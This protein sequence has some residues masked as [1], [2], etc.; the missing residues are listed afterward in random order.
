MSTD[1]NNVTVQGLNR[2]QLRQLP[3]T[4]GR[5]PIE[6]TSELKTDNIVRVDFEQ[7][8]AVAS[9]TEQQKSSQEST[10]RVEQTDSVK[11]SIQKLSDSSQLITRKLEFHIDDASGKT[12]ITVK[13]SS[14]KEVIRQIPSEQVLEISARFEQ[15][16]QDKNSDPSSEAQGILFT[17]TT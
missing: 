8:Q 13:D 3:E 6:S 1:I 11:Q 12:V 10:E 15:A 17:S 7:R 14:T 5:E 16:Q 4:T 2:P 9:L